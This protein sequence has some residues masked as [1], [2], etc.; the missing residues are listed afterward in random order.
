VEVETKAESNR[1][2]GQFGIADQR[3]PQS[4]AEMLRLQGLDPV[5][6]D[7]DASILAA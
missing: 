7:W 4:V 3:S 2:E 5:W 6:K 1:A